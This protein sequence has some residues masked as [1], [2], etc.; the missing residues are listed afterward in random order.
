MVQG[1]NFDF[2]LG[3]NMYSNSSWENIVS[4]LSDNLTSV[5]LFILHTYA[6]QLDFLD[7]SFVNIKAT[8]KIQIEG[9]ASEKIHFYIELWAI[10]N[11]AEI[12]FA[13]TIFTCPITYSSAVCTC[14]RNRLDRWSGP[15]QSCI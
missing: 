2:S 7:S 12:V 15:W 11:H 8:D 13:A 1:V 5:R 4:R 10:K 6:S 3:L 14:K 9:F